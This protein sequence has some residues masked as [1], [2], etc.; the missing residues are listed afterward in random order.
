LAERR[1]RS[2]RLERRETSRARGLPP[3]LRGALAK[4][5]HEL[6]CRMEGVGECGPVFERQCCAHVIADL[7]QQSSAS[8]SSGYATRTVTASSVPL[9][10]V[11]SLARR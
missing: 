8:A 2:R 4:Q 7:R 6:G 5:P 3:D 1:P 10:P 9:R 11:W